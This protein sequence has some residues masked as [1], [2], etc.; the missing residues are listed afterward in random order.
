MRNCRLKGSLSIYIFLSFFF[1][2]LY[3]IFFRYFRSAK[4]AWS[5]YGGPIIGES[6]IKKLVDVGPK[7]VHVYQV[8]ND[9]PWKVNSLDVV[10][11]WPY[12]VANDKPHGKWLLYLEETP[13]MQGKEIVNSAY[14]RCNVE[15]KIVQLLIIATIL[16]YLDGIECQVPQ[17]R[18]NPL[19]LLGSIGMEDIDPLFPAKTNPSIETNQTNHV[20]RRRDTEKVV[21]TKIIIDKDGHRKS[22]VS[23]VN[24]L[25][26]IHRIFERKLLRF[27]A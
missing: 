23:M 18:V 13:V 2:Y 7:V 11:S 16:C 12:E 24:F 25:V 9:G 5:S 15:K 21:T 26:D 22:V 4:V 19:N 27:F 17:G 6:A 10:I 20:R 3:C 8:F 1:S 14:N